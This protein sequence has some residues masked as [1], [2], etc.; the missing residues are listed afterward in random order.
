MCAENNSSERA[1]E[2]EEESKLAY[3]KVWSLDLNGWRRRV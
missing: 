1:E 3:Q 2:E